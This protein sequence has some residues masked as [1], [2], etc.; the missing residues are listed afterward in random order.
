MPDRKRCCACLTRLSSHPGIRRDMPQ[1]VSRMSDQELLAETDRCYFYASHEL[2]I[3]R[4]PILVRWTK[5]D[6]GSGGEL[7]RNPDIDL[8]M[9]NAADPNL[10]A[11]DILGALG[12]MHRWPKETP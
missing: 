5:A 1:L 11:A 4:L 2:G 12:S 7:H 10:K 9:R 3:T 6:V 8:A